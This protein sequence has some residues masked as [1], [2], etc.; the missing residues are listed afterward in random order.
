MYHLDFVEMTFSSEIP[1]LQSFQLALWNSSV[2][3][4]TCWLKKQSMQCWAIVQFSF[5][6]SSCWFFPLINT[7]VCAREVAGFGSAPFSISHTPFLCWGGGV[8]FLKGCNIHLRQVQSLWEDIIVLFLRGALQHFTLGADCS[9]GPQSPVTEEGTFQRVAQSQ[10]LVQ[11]LAVACSPLTAVGI[12]GNK[13]DY[14]TW[15]VRYLNLDSVNASTVKTKSRGSC[16]LQMTLEL[17]TKT[18]APPCESP[19]FVTVNLFS[20][21]FWT[22]CKRG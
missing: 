22:G 8:L 14:I 7:T 12:K 9:W 16:S 5:L 21:V 19:D 10:T 20:T 15:L 13:T 18:L 1:V 4:C 11:A 17:H 2:R 3:A 6:W